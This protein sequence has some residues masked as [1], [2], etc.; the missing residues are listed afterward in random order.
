MIIHRSS[1]GNYALVTQKP[2]VG[3]A[4]QGKQQVGEVEVWALEVF[5]VAHI[6]QA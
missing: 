6:S 1:G 5:S 3:R 2:L 4:K